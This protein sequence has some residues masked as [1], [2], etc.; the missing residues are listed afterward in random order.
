MRL[1]YFDASVLCGVEEVVIGGN[2]LPSHPILMCAAPAIHAFI[3]DPDRTKTVV[4][5]RQSR[6]GGKLRRVWREL[7]IHGF[8]IAGFFV[9]LFGDR[10]SAQPRAQIFR[11][12]S[13][14]FSAR[15]GS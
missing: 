14:F 1:R 13:V 10:N 9:V 6:R 11:K 4:L 15:S 12:F 7:G 5:Q 2:D 3:L 8:P